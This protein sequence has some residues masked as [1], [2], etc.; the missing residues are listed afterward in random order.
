VQ[1]T[2]WSIFC[3]TAAIQG[4]RRFER[5][6]AVAHFDPVNRACDYHPAVGAAEPDDD[7][8]AV[9]GRHVAGEHWLTKNE[10]I[11]HA[12]PAS[13]TDPNLCSRGYSSAGTLGDRGKD[14]A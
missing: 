5:Y 9:G 8:R 2:G 4:R 6:G 12:A 11:K 7:V 3:R 1:Y 10:V 14:G 13:A